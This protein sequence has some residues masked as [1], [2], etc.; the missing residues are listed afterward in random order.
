MPTG[1]MRPRP[2][3]YRFGARGKGGGRCGEVTHT[4]PSAVLLTL[5]VRLCSSSSG[6]RVLGTYLSIGARTTRLS[7]GHGSSSDP[8][9]WDDS[10]PLLRNCAT[11]HHS[12]SPAPMLES[13][14]SR[15]PWPANRC[16]AVARVGIATVLTC[17]WTQMLNIIQRNV[18]LP[19]L[20]SAKGPMS[21][22]LIHIFR[23]PVT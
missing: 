21:T 1:V 12:H 10:M 13:K 8:D 20:R 18:S 6:F 9:C 16:D 23:G 2:R 4:E 17:S 14:S 22:G 19:P 7:P 11:A 15:E 5:F 3:N